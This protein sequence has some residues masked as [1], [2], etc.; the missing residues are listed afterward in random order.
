MVRYFRAAHT[1]TFRLLLRFAKQDTVRPLFDRFP[2]RSTGNVE[3]MSV[4]RVTLIDASLPPRLHSRWRHGGVA[5]SRSDDAD[6]RHVRAVAWQL[7]VRRALRRHDEQRADDRADEPGSSQDP[8]VRHSRVGDFAAVDTC[9]G[10]VAPLATCNIQVTF[11]PTAAGTRTGSITIT[12]TAKASNKMTA[13]LSGTGVAAGVDPFTLGTD[14]AHLP[15]TFQ[16]CDVRASTLV[17]T[18]NQLIPA[19][20]ITL[21]TAGPFSATG[22]AAPLGAG[23][24]CTITVTFAPGATDVG[25]VAG[26]LTATSSTGANASASLSGTA[27]RRVTVAPDPLPFGNVTV[28]STSAPSVIT[29]TNNQSTRINLGNPLITFGGPAAASTRRPPRPADRG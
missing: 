7:D 24:S 11:T 19:T 15:A 1:G 6:G 21:A 26:Q 8:A 13:S 18:N 12:D 17:L 27:L 16:G 4:D 14:I 20:G 10:T 23:S 28:A 5:V 22:C 29:V 3:V 9:G 25:A 2:L